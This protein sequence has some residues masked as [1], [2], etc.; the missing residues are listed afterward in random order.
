MSLTSTNGIRGHSV[1]TS[2]YFRV[3]LYKGFKKTKAG[4]F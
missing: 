3:L 1:M 2:Y 4:I